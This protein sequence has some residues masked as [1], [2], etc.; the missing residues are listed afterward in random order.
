M[1]VTAGPDLNWPLVRLAGWM[2]KP[3]SSFNPAASSP[4]PLPVSPWHSQHLA[5]T[6]TSFPCAIKAG[7]GGGGAGIYSGWPGG[8]LTKNS[9]GFLGSE[10]ST[11][12][13]YL[14][15]WI[16]ARRSFNGK[17]YQ[18]GMAVPRT[19]RVMVRS[20]SPSLGTGSSVS[21]NLKTPAVKLRGR[22]LY[23]NVA[24]GPLPSPFTPWQ[25]TQRRS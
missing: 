2:V 3:E 7:V 18:G 22:W 23:R 24:A 9:E 21:R 5:W 14:M 25:P 12:S 16:T 4:S 17:S 15:Y 20:M 19:P 11:A 8:A 10:R 6:Q 1:S 13:A